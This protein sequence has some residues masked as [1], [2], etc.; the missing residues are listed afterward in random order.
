MGVNASVQTSTVLKP[1]V[2]L[3]VMLSGGSLASWS[4]TL[5]A[6]TVS[7]QDSPPIKFVSGLMVN[8][9]GPPLTTPDLIPLTEQFNS[10][11]AP[12]TLTDSVKVIVRLV[13]TG[14]PAVPSLG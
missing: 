6:K 3:S 14:T 9:V 1:A 5:A 4:V 2:K 7:V 11:Q 8:T 13:S 10:Y 12:L